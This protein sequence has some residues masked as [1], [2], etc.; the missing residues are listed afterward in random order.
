VVVSNAELAFAVATRLFAPPVPRYSGISDQA[1]IHENSRIGKGVSIYPMAYVGKDAVIGDETILFSGA[2]I[3]DRVKVGNRAVI[4]PNVT[5]LQD[6]LIGNDVIIHAGTVIGSDGFGYVR[7]GSKSV[8]IPQIG[9]VQID[10]HVEIGANNCI[11]R[12]ALGKTWLKRGVKTDNLVQV[13]HNV[14]IGQVGIVDHM[15]V[16]DRAVVGPRA[17][18]AKPI[19]PGEVMSGTPAMPHRLW[20]KTSVLIRQL[21]QLNKRLRDL[22]K[23]IE[24]L[25]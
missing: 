22:E 14:I 15:E 18:V 20:L 16:G 24:E 2:F 4:Y 6:C 10:D 7:D 3:G 25:E 21:P 17:G 11:D 19:L 13:A 23:K 1:F 8:K 9:I 5:I 12:A